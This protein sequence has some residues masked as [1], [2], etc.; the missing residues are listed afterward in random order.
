MSCDVLGLVWPGVLLF[1]LWQLSLS[2]GY[3][4]ICKLILAL[5]S[6]DGD[7]F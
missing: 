3:Y 7:V 1:G 5:C 6:L 4:S 2:V